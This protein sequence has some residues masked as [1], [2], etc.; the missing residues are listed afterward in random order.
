[1]ASAHPVQPP[2]AAAAMC[3]VYESWPRRSD[4][5]TLQA[6]L[7]LGISGAG[8]HVY[9]E[10]GSVPGG[11]GKRGK[12]GRGRSLAELLMILLNGRHGELETGLLSEGSGRRRVRCASWCGCVH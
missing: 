9:G 3:R 11:R 8:D 5:R 12:H 7:Q 2:R 6:E 10:T 1:M 4:H